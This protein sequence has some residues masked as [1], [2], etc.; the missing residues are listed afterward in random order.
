LNLLFIAK[1]HIEEAGLNIGTHR[2]EKL[3][4]RQGCV[5]HIARISPEQLQGKIHCKPREYRELTE[6]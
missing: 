4:I 3:Q 2:E 1:Y 5:S 6:G